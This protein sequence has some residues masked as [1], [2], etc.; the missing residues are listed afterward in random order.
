[1]G[2]LT[3][4]L[5]HLKQTI[6]QLGPLKSELKKYNKNINLEQERCLGFLVLVLD[7]LSSRRVS[8]VLEYR[9]KQG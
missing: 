5:A 1:M 4:F 2:L 8:G 6:I 3:F 9:W 7:V